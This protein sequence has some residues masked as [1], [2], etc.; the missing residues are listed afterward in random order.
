MVRLALRW[1]LTAVIGLAAGWLIAEGAHP[2]AIGTATD[3][4]PPA[5]RP[6]TASQP[7][8]Y[9][10]ASV[11]RATEQVAAALTG[12]LDGSFKIL[13]KPPFVIAGNLSEADLRSYASGSIV[14]PGRAMWSSYFDR[15]PDKVITVILLADADSYRTW[16][17]KLFGDTDVSY[18]GYY[19]PTDRTLVLDIHTGTGTLV[20]ELTHALIAFDWPDVPLWFNEGLASLHE[21]CR[22]GVNRITG[23]PNWRLRG[24]QQAIADNRLRPLADLI[25][26]PDFNGPLRG[27][28]YAHAR[29]FCMYLQSRGLLTQFYRQ[30]RASDQKPATA[31]KLIEKL[32]GRPVGEVDAGLRKYVGTL[33]WD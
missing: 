29:Y 11:V 33:K 16:A 6:A 18:F 23:L 5:T 4:P 19:R 28:N 10:T 14:R 15:R 9:P 7:A 27:L 3:A 26:D 25:A 13:I 30:Y 22:V 32:C 8:T 24:L 31:V 12:K 1:S 17:Q 2:R 21:Q 20:H